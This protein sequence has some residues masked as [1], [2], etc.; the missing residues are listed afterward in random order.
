MKIFFLVLMFAAGVLGGD[1]AGRGRPESVELRQGQE[2]VFRRAG[3]RVKLLEIQE[4][5]RC[6]QGVECIWAGNVRVVLLVRGPGR[7]S[8]R[9]TLNTASEPRELKLGGRT[10]T[11][12]K[13]SPPKIIDRDIRPRDYRITLTLAGD[14]P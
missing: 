10:F 5:S 2:R 12:S 1:G 4:D 6:P 14:N 13:V 11:I 8:R 7:A 9:E 3:V